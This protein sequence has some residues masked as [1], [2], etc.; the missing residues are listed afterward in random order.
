MS[1]YISIIIIV[2]ICFIFGKEVKSYAQ[3]LTNDTNFQEQMKSHIEKM[4]IKS[5]QKYQAMIQ[6]AG[7]NL[8]HCCSCHIEVKGCAGYIPAKQPLTP[9]VLTPKTPKKF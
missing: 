4:K 6:R 3:P 9:Q 2:C 8:T 5:P 1:K 7:G